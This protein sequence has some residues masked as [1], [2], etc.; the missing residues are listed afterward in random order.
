MSYHGPKVR[1][2]RRFGVAWT[3]KGE[4]VLARRPN[5]PGQHG[6]SRRRSRD[7]VYKKQLIQKQLVRSQYNIREK[8]MHNYYLKA[9][10][11]RG[12]YDERLIQLLE[13]RLDALVLHAGFAQTIY[14]ARQYVSHGHVL[15]NNKRVSYPSYAV[16]PGDVISIKP[17]FQESL[18]SQ[19]PDPPAVQPPYLS[20]S[21]EKFEAQLLRLPAAREVPVLGD[22]R[23]VIE[24]YSR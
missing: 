6:N 12:S 14:A 11:S 4:K 5:P 18:R 15:V 24:F 16:Q 22:L 23:Q 8:Q 20:T 21:A 13:T 2:A 1:L 9:L 3:P 10:K 17:K 19:V 7:S